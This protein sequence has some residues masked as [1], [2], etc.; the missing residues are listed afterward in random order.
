MNIKVDLYLFVSMIILLLFHQ[1]VPF[2]TFYVFVI[3]HELAHTLMAVLLRIPVKELNFLPFGVNAKFEFGKHLV[4]EILVAIAGPLFS[5]FVAYYFPAYR[6]ENTFICVMNLLPIY[7][8]DGGRILKNLLLLIMGMEVALKVYH[9]LL[10]IFIILF[11][12]VNIILI[13]YL[14]R[15]QFLFVTCYI[16]QMA[17]E[18]M[19]KDKIRMKMK[20]IL[21]LDF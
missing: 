21:N 18:E 7:P 19:K 17:G 11:L 6:V 12:I 9:S 13:I 8:L 5:F 3:L 20:E 10:R 14:K 15:Y 4:R 16:F 2:L 1:I